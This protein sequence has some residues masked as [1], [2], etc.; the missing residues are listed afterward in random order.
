VIVHRN[1]KLHLAQEIDRD[2][3]AAEDFGLALLPAEPLH[4]H[5]GEAHDLDFGEGGFDVFQ[6]TGLDYGDDE[7]HEEF[8]MWISECGIS[9][10]SLKN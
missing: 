2:F 9:K 10:E 5:D 1:L 6:L 3:P 4:V 7:L 8:G